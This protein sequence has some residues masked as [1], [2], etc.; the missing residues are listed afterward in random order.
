[1]KD[2]FNDGTHDYREYG[3]VMEWRTTDGRR[4]DEMIERG[5]LGKVGKRGKNESALDN[6][7]NF[8][9]LTL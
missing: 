8:D 4:G 7:G 3:A 2:E 5:I 6:L 9:K 1:M